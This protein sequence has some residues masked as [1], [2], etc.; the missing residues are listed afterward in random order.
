MSRSARINN[1]WER[2]VCLKF[3]FTLFYKYSSLPLP[4]LTCTSGG[5]LRPGWRDILDCWDTCRTCGPCLT[6][7]EVGRAEG[8]APERGVSDLQRHL[9]GPFNRGSKSTG[10][11][12]HSCW[13][14]SV[15]HFSNRPHLRQ[16]LHR[17]WMSHQNDIKC[18][19]ISVQADLVPTVEPPDIP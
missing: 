3:T 18:L 19:N 8:K 10:T 11:S 6:S 17:G 7:A 2:I 4:Q 5:N 14:H 16:L 9:P 13:W 12:T 1:L 15:G